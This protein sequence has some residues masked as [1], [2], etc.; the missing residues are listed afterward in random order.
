MDYRARQKKFISAAEDAHVEGFL[1]THLPNI[2]YLSGFTGSAGALAYARGRFAFFTDGR[3]REQAR[4]EVVGATVVISKKPALTAAAEWLAGARVR[5]V[6]VEAEHMTLAART[7]AARAVKVSLKPT[8]GLVECLRMVKEPAEL[9]CIRRAVQLGSSLFDTVVEAIRP[10]VSE[11][12]VAA[13]LEYAARAAGAEKMAF[14]SIVAGGVHSAFPHWRASS[15]PIPNTGF[16]VLDFGVILAG[17][18]SDMTR[19]VWVGKPD[20]AAR[21][22][23]QAVL[24]AQRAGLE[25]VRPGATTGEV[26]RAARNMLRRAGLARYFTHSTGHGVGL[27]IHEA[28]RLARGQTEVLRPGMV[29]TIE[30]GAYIPG[31]GGV[32]IEDMVA[33]TESGHQVLTPTTKEFTSI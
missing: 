1:V 25:A 10:G 29:V 22:L 14:E 24:E 13:E 23:Y 16:V 20:P 21:D 18:C 33:V 17:Y 19:T 12:S 32:R 11:A 2:R 26:D 7:V 31:K 4:Q 5:R 9:E 30:P 27:E 8:A 6:G 3:Y 28:P 15:Q